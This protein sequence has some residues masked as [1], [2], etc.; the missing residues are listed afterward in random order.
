[1]DAPTSSSTST[2]TT[3]INIWL[4]CQKRLYFHVREKWRL[5][6]NTSSSTERKQRWI[7][8]GRGRFW[9]ARKC[10]S[11]LSNFKLAIAVVFRLNLSLRRWGKRSQRSFRDKKERLMIFRGHANSN[12]EWSPAQWKALSWQSLFRIWGECGVDYFDDYQEFHIRISF[13]RT[14]WQ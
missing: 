6:E 8:S 11:N 3:G 7:K 2:T 10:C 1:M 4:Q 13:H 14:D 12:K 5:T 9:L